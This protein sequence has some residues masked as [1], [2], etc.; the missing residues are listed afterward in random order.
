MYDSENTQDSYNIK[1]YYEIM[2]NCVK[3]KLCNLNLYIKNS[4][5][6]SGR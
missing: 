4:C 5:L 1:K 6:L 2:K 3:K